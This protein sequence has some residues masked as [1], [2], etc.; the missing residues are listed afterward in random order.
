[1][2]VAIAKLCWGPNI[3]GYTVTYEDGYNER[4]EYLS[5]D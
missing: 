4:Y 1:M 5:L 2:H 3:L